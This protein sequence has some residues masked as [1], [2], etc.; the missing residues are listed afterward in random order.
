MPEDPSSRTPDGKPARTGKYSYEG[1]DD[2]LVRACLHGDSRA[3][4]TL[5]ERYESFIFTIA[6]RRGLARPD[7]EDVFQNV[8]VKL[9]QHLS[10]LRDVRKLS[11]WIAAVAVR[12]TQ[13]FYRKDPVRLFSETVSLSDDPD[14]D[15]TGKV[16]SDASPED[17]LLALER[18]EVV[19]Q[20][21]NE[22]SDECRKL[23]TMLYTSDEPRSYSEAAEELKIPIGSIGPKRARC[24]ARLRA[25]LARVGY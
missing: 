15:D 6:L 5:I 11:G 3:W 9:Y 25:L 18:T 19:R 10:D 12:E 24:L 2:D 7:A 20:S 1:S 21:L 17:E 8:C 14:A 23:I 13:M 22:L 4:K 16:S